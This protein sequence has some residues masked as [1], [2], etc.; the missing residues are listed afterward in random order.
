MLKVSTESES[1][2]AR[3]SQIEREADAFGRIIGVRRLK[4]SEQAKLNGMCQDLAGFDESEMTKE[5]GEVV[6]LQVPHRLPLA[7]VAAVCE[8][9]EAETGRVIKVPFPRNRGELDSLY[10]RLDS[11]GFQAASIAVG[12]LFAGADLSKNAVDAAKN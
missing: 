9:T 1:K 4:L 3:Y 5:D 10:D 8:I 11:E 6:K 7:I 12:R 2:L